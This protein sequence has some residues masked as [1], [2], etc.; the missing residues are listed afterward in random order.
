MD[1][2]IKHFLLA[3]LGAG[4]AAL[5]LLEPYHVSYID[6]KGIPQV[7]F[8]KFVRYEIGPRKIESR[9]VGHR[10][11]KFGQVLIVEE[12]NLTRVSS[13]G[14]EMVHAD[15]AVIRPE[16]S[17]EL[18][19][20]VLLVRSDGWIMKAPRL[21]YDIRRDLY[22]TRGAP[23]VITYGES[24]VHGKALRYFRKSGKIK[25]KNIRARIARKDL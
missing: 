13:H 5:F 20:D 17:V 11:R 22:T 15:R 14:E 10:A 2:N 6:K 25:A 12:A 16:R 19:G 1:L 23:F 9:V 8:D 24:V 21:Y 3:L 7:V 4:V 18:K